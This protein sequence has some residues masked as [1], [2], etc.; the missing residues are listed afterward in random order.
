[1]LTR[2]FFVSPCLCGKQRCMTWKHLRSEP[3]PD[4]G[5]FQSRFDWLENPRN[6]HSLKAVVLEVPD[7]INVAAFTPEGKVVVVHQ[8][9]FGMRKT[10]T[11]IP[12]GI[13]EDGESHEN[14]AKRELLEE[15]G[16]STDR[17]EYLGW[18]EPNPAFQ[19]NRCHQWVARDVR[20]TNRQNL[21]DG[22]AI[23]VQELSV[24]EVRDKIHKGD[25][26]NSLALLTLSR[27][28]D[29]WGTSA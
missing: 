18:V 5:I 29:V 9:R 15:T 1:M 27:V 10:T 20:R 26:R 2:R 22:E 21:D 6:S 14:A 17:W 12:A 24:E 13:I 11:E 16:Y 25:M 23:A 7:W 3:G 28:L 4:F 19:N 8:Y